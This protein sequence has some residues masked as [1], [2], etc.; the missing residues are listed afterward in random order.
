MSIYC[1]IKLYTISE[2]KNVII[3]VKTVGVPRRDAEAAVRA[4]TG[5]GIIFWCPDYT[6]KDDQRYDGH[7]H[8]SPPAGASSASSSPINLRGSR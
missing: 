6:D 4:Q 5:G 1:I 8:V 2:F 7:A 3:E